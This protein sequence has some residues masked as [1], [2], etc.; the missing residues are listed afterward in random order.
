MTTPSPVPSARSRN[1][2]LALLGVVGGMAIYWTAIFVVR[3]P[4]LSRCYSAGDVAGGAIF[5]LLVGPPAIGTFVAVVAVALRKG[6]IWS[7]GVGA[8]V[9]LASIALLAPC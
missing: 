9:A 3:E 5:L 7:W 1:G 8:G 6:L 4:I 2:W